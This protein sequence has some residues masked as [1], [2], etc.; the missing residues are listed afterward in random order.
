MSSVGTIFHLKS[1]DSTNSEV[2]RLQHDHDLENG[3]IVIADYQTQGRGRNYH[4]WESRPGDNLLFSSWI[5]LN[6]EFSDLAG[7]SLL[8]SLAVTDI[9]RNMG[10]EA[11]CKWPNDI[12][13]DGRKV[14]GI[15]IECLSS[16]GRMKGAVIGIGIN[17][18]SCPNNL[19]GHNESTCIA[20]YVQTTPSLEEMAENITKKLMKYTEE[21]FSGNHDELI[22]L[23]KTRCDHMNK[24][25]YVSRNGDK[26]LGMTKDVNGKG[27]LVLQIGDE[28]ITIT[29]DEIICNINE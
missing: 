25:V 8:P 7:Y 20:E 22:S 2:K 3:T 26:I 9:L 21:W 19:G 18:S 29:S 14:G 4:T 10:V 12:R 15:L 6:T 23:W 5:Q 27:D 17:I 16:R 1:V 11:R 13:I 24:Q 28:L